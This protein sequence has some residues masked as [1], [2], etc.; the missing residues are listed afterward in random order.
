VQ[1]TRQNSERSVW[2]VEDRWP[3]PATVERKTA[4]SRFKTLLLIGVSALLLSVAAG[5]MMRALPGKANTASVAPELSPPPASTEVKHSSAARHLVKEV[6]PSS[7]SPRIPVN[8]PQIPLYPRLG[9]N[10][11]PAY[12]SKSQ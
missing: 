4:R 1:T 5:G 11:T 7:D 10:F 3:F 6:A 8:Y 2:S 9:G 12:F